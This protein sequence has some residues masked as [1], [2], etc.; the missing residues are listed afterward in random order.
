MYLNGVIV[1]EFENK[2][3]YFINGKKRNLN[4]K[5]NYF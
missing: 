2:I 3:I 4:N 1:I 5:I